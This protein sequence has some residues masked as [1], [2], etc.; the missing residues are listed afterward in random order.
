MGTHGRMQVQQLRLQAA[1][2][3]RASHFEVT[4]VRAASESCGG[5]GVWADEQQVPVMALAHE[6]DWIEPLPE[7][8]Q[9]AIYQALGRGHRTRDTLALRTWVEQTRCP[10]PNL[11]AVDG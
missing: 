2:V 8:R 10:W 11:E 7:A 9:H 1:E 3:A 4:L 5:D 6:A